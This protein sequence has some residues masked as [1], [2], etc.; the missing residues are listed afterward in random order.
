MDISRYA[1]LIFDCD[2]VVLD[3]NKVKT[4]AFYNAAL[5]YG[6]N[7][8]EA[9]MEYHKK[10]G[11]ISRYVK[12]EYFLKKIVKTRTEQTKLDILLDDYA[13]QVRKGLLCCQISHGLKKLRQVT[14]SRWLVVSGGDQNELRDIFSQRNLAESFN[15]GIFGSPDTKDAI[16]SRELGSANIK[17][18]ALFIGDSKYDHQA[19]A[20]ANIDFVFAY[21]LT[22]VSDWREYC[23]GNKLD[24]IDNIS[25]LHGSAPVGTL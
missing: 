22:E 6:V 17:L 23:D 1:T 24:F 8:A 11:G 5:P 20:T 10:H 19:A 13:H 7:A 12:F 2:G 9:L 3:S 4:V 15:G 21:G 25:Q 18:P 14:Q 16:L